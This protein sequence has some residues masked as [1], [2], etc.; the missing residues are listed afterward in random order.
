MRR[1][2]W[3][4]GAKKSRPYLDKARTVTAVLT[5]LESEYCHVTLVAELGGVRTGFLAGGVGLVAGLGVA[6]GTAVILGAPALLLAATAVP[7]LGFG[8][9]ITRAYRPIVERARLG[10][11]RALDHLEQ[12][13][14]LSSP[15]P[16]QGGD[17]AREVGAVVRGI[18]QEVRKAIGAKKP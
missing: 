17:L 13:P 3:A 11:A 1:V 4:L 14:R 8:W 16:N 7:S 6:A 12:R 9:M 10:L 18:T 15:P 2:G 5:P